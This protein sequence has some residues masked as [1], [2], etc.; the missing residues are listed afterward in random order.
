MYRSFVYPCREKLI[1]KLFQFTVIVTWTSKAFSGDPSWDG[2]HVARNS[3]ISY[4]VVNNQ[5]NQIN[6]LSGTCGSNFGLVP[7]SGRIVKVE[8]GPDALRVSG[9]VVEQSA[10]DR[11]YVN[12]DWPSTEMGRADLGWIAQ[13]LRQF[14]RSGSQID[15]DGRLCGASGGVEFLVNIRQVKATRPS[16]KSSEPAPAEP[17]KPA[18]SDLGP[19]IVEMVEDGGTLAVPVTINGQLTLKFVVDSGASDVAVPADVAMTLIRTG[20]IGKADFLGEQTYRMAD[21]SALP[22]RSFLIHSLKVGDKVLENVTGSITPVEGSLLLGQSFL[23]RFKSW[24]I[25]NKKGLLIL[26]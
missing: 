11:S 20:T 22:S 6:N 2:W 12:V 19:T 17:L 13:G 26:N 9:I 18:G 1:R 24:S 23:S 8:F 14:L 15:G 21:G 7:I 3:T 25:D 16:G 4:Q 10:G 5:V